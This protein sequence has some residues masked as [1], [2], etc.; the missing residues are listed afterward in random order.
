[1]KATESIHCFRNG[2]IR[3][4]LRLS[5]I[6]F[7]L[8]GFFVA[9]SICPAAN[10]TVTNTADSGPGT[11]RALIA[12]SHYGD[13]I[14]FSEN[15]AGATITLTNG[16]IE[17]TNSFLFMD[18]IVVAPTVIISGNNA[19]RIF[20]IDP[21]AAVFIE[22]LT[23]VN[24]MV[25]ND[26]GGA[27]RNDGT[28][29]VTQCHFF[30]NAA[31]GGVGQ[32]AGNDYPMAGGS[33]GGGAGLGGAIF[34]DGATLRLGGC[35]FSG[36]LAQGGNGGTGGADYGDGQTNFNG[37]AG[38]GPAGGAGGTSAFTAGNPGGFGS[39]GGGGAST[40]ENAPPGMGGT[41]GF[42]G[43]GG[44]TGGSEYVFL[45]VGG[46]AGPFGGPGGAYTA[47]NVTG[48]GGGGAG[49]GGAVFT[50]TGAVNVNDCTFIGNTATKGSG[51]ISGLMP[52]DDSGEGSD[53]TGYGGAL[54]NM[55]PNLILTSSTFTSNAAT[56]GLPDVF[57]TPPL[58]MALTNGN[59]QFTW[60][61][62]EPGFALEFSPGFSPANWQPAS[63]S[64][65][66]N[67]SVNTQTVTPTPG[68]F[69]LYIPGAAGS[70]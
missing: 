52:G 22:D 47:Q 17:I 62:N 31:H 36:N 8:A 27:I 6:L 61:T 51:G 67:G 53:G 13:T 65:T 11:L 60:P 7:A 19:S 68:F 21:G 50:Q 30:T 14:G 25:T 18:G 16:Q 3:K 70:L 1:M 38:G 63:G 66:T 55:S 20:L 49:L 37:V 12:A 42:G 40:G 45:S 64:S 69:R 9:V 15:L 59:L 56:T 48:A 43:G 29:V 35:Y 39:G 46:T 32:S 34:S 23:F 54:F 41:G 57:T 24:G 4:C 10:L 33:G 5:T 2:S 28:L 26:F 58:T 44:G